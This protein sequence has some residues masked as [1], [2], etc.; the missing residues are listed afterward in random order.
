MRGN[1]SIKMGR[2]LYI[3]SRN[4]KKIKSKVVKTAAVMGA[5]VL[6]A[7]PVIP[8]IG[9]LGF[10]T[11]SVSAAYEATAKVTKVDFQN[12]E[13]NVVNIQNTTGTIGDEKWVVDA[14]NNGKLQSRGSDAQFNNGTKIT[15]PVSGKGTITVVSYPNYHN[16]TVGGKEV[17]KDTYVYEYDVA[18]A[19]DATVDIVATGTSYLY[20]IEKFEN[21]YKP[22][23]EYNAENYKTGTKTYDFTN[24]S[25]ASADKPVVNQV[26]NKTDIIYQN[27]GTSSGCSFDASQLRFRPDVVLLIPLKDD[28]TAIKYTMTGAGNNVGRPTYFGSKDSGYKVEYNYT[29]ELMIDDVD[30]LTETIDGKKYLKIISGGDIKIKKLEITEYN[31]VTTVSVSGKAG[32]GVDKVVYKNQETGVLYTADV[33][34]DGN[35]SVNLKRVKGNTKYSIAVVSDDYMVDPN[36]NILNLIGNDETFTNDIT[37]IEAKKARLTGK[38][39]GIDSALLKGE[40]KATL[41]PE[42]SAFPSVNVTL[43]ADKDGSYSFNDVAALAGYKYSL[44]LESADD[45][46]VTDVI[47]YAEGTYDSVSITATKKATQTVS[48]KFVTS[49]DGKSDITEITFT[50]MDTPDY[51]YTFTVDG[52]TYTAKLRAGE[53]KTT[54]KS[55]SGKYSAY[56]HVSVSDSEAANDV[57]LQGS[58]DNSE[59]VYQSQIKVG[60]GQ[61]FET[62]AK[63]V[64]YVSRMTRTENQR[65]TIVL[66]DAMYREQIIIDTPNVTITSDRK[67]GSTISWYYGVG[68]SYYSAKLS[69]DKKS[70]YYD[71]AYAVD[72]YYKQMISQNPGHWG[73]TVN[74]FF[75]AKGFK[76]EGITFENSFNRYMTTEEVVDGVG[77][78]QMN[79]SADRSAPDINVKAY[80]SKERS[81]VLYIQADDTEYSNCKLLSSQD[82]LYTGDSTESSYFS[83]CVI[84]GNTD[85]ICG[86]GNAVFDNC[87]LSMYGYSDKNATDSIIV[88]NKKKAES[89]Y[90]FNNCKVV[91]TSFEGL[92]PTDTFYLA[93]SW[94]RGCKLAFIN[95]EIAND[96]KVIDEGFTN[97]NGDKTNVADSVMKEYNTH[98]SD[99]V[100]AD[101]SKRTK[102]TIILTKEQA[103]AI[104]IPS[105]LGDF[106]A[107]YYYADYTKVDE[108][109][110]AADKLNAAD[111]LN[112]SEVAK[113][114]EAVVRN[115]AKQEQ[116]KVDSMAD[117]I[118][119]AISNLVKASSGVDTGKDAPSVEVK[120]SV[121]DLID[122]ILS[123]DQKKDAEGKD[124]K[125]VLS[126]N[127]DIGVNEDDKKAAEK[128]L[129]EL[130]SGK[131]A[132]MYLDID[133]NVMIGN[134][135]ISVTETKK[136]I[137]IEVSV[138][139]E[140]IN[141]DANKTR[142][143][144]VL[145]VHNGK[146]DVL[147]ATYDENTKKLLFKSDVFS[148]YVLVYE[149]TV[150]NPIPENPTP[151]NPTPENPTPE[152]PTPENPTPEN[153]SQ[154]NPTTEAPSTDEPATETPA[155]TEIKDGDKSAQTG[156]KSPIAALVSLLGLSGLGIFAPTKKKRV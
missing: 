70:A 35:Y 110:A 73:A 151:E 144:S 99:G 60:T 15:I 27:A 102:G 128:K 1:A 142:K 63:A 87:T 53:Y 7:S 133:L 65:V 75:G 54:V 50:N 111:Y 113:A 114:K 46:E 92:K 56:D 3:M 61:Q 94:D 136:P 13:K 131:K 43:T 8:S 82:T 67:A 74:L 79:S 12:M 137:A 127:K 49:D 156:D 21:T 90:L 44:V 134:G 108:A 11:I 107:T 98:N 154:E 101:T 153:P 115:L 84:E 81:C 96:T 57:Y 4:R 86:D 23:F 32:E 116:S 123:D 138:P 109:I 135:N 34:S 126:V 89:G 14:S 130:S 145:R 30:G 19:K 66:T 100:A 139:D 25:T 104:D 28:T 78:G 106:N 93:R 150:K 58:V 64:S 26:L 148:T 119:N 62:I 20:S 140:L 68:Y 120:E 22:D 80:K 147:D 124:V 72:K 18:D 9:E 47:E 76:A 6:A 117:A 37:L 152:N 121:S 97:M 29:S 103:D 77:K 51:K 122:N 132:G 95:T 24:N 71:E 149:D 69:A 52:G 125:I 39:T 42:D 33:D 55:T 129:A 48:G 141:T 143:Y 2:F 105:Y 41:V 40:L 146:V 112:F 16:Y 17:D 31:P 36:K 5:L 10:G 59:V 83:D 85:Y 91:N 155:G 118:N 38:I 45:Y 88:A